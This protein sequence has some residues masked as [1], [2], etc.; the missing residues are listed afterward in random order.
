MRLKLCKLR[1]VLVNLVGRRKACSFLVDKEG[2][3]LTCF[4]LDPSCKYN[5]TVGKKLV[6]LQTGDF[7][8]AVKACLS[9][10]GGFSPR[11]YT[12]YFG[13]KVVGV[14]GWIPKLDAG[15]ILEIEDREFFGPVSMVKRRLWSLLLVIG[16]GA[17][18]MSIFVGRRVSEPLISLT[19]TAKKMASG[20]LE[21]RSSIKSQD[22]LGE[23]AESLNT[24]V[25]SFQK[26]HAELEEANKKLADASVI[27]GLTGLYNHYHFQEMVDSEYRRARRYD[28]PL[29]LLM[30]DIDNFKLINDTYGHPFG[31]F[32]L[33]ELARIINASIRDTDIT[34]RYGGEEFTVILPNTTLDGSYAVAEKL[35]QT[36]AD[37]VFKQ[38]DFIVRLSLTVGISALAEEGINTKDDLVKHADEAMYE[39]KMKGKNMVVS[40]GEFILWERLASKGERESTEHYRE[41]FVSTANSLKRSYMEAA[42]TL[43]K[44]LDAKD[45]YSATHSYLVAAYAVRLAEELGLSREKTDIIKNSAILHDIGKI[46][47]PTNILTKTDKLTEEEHNTL[48]THPEQSVRILED[49][50]FLEKEIPIILHHQEWFNGEGYPG[51]L[52]GTAIPLGTR[53]L[54]ICDSYE[55]M[56]SERPYRKSLTYKAAIEEIRKGAGK[57]FDPHLVEPFIRAMEK[58]LTTVRRIYIPQLNKTVDIA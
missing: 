31:D 22:E 34:S 47:I 49:I 23:L 45:G 58:L 13:E 36:V 12:N 30:I 53:I 16:I 4:M 43:V 33:K 5:E 42:T 38:G 27:D 56:T 7:I 14:W 55:A 41:R 9:G 17:I 19:E 32:V 50:G 11:V 3:T 35:R 29:S 18:V 54:A 21:E 46:A 37:H 20:D 10:K 40:W 8:P 24:M 26:E 15:L 25:E 44:S 2:K 1:E 51:G 52:K 6:D 28:L 57:Q 48:N 39:G